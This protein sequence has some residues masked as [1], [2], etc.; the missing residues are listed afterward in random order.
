MSATIR[1]CAR[2][3]GQ[4][5]RT[6][7]A[8]GGSIRR[9][10][11][12]VALRQLVDRDPAA[13]APRMILSSMSVMFMT[14]VTGQPRQ[15]RWRTSRSAN[16]KRPEVADV[17][18]A[19][20]R[21]AARVDP[22]RS[23]AERH[24]RPG[25]AG[26]RVVEADGHRAASTMATAQRRDRPPGAL[27]AVE[28]AGRRLDVDG[29]PREAEQAGDRV[30]HRVE[31]VAQARPR[32]DDGHVDPPGRQPGGREPRRRPRRASRAL[33]MPERRRGAGR[34]QTAEV[35]ERR[36]PRAAHRRRRGGRRR[37]RSGRAAAAR[38][39]I[40]T[41]PSTQRRRPVRTDGCRG[42]CPMRACPVRDR[43]AAAAREIGGHGDLEV[44]R[45]ARD[46]MDRDAPPP[47][48]RPRPSRSPVRRRVPRDSAARSSAAADALG[49][50][51]GAERRSGR[52]SRRRR[53]PSIRLSVSATG[54]TGIAAP[55]RR[56]RARPRDERRR[57]RAAAR[58]RGRGPRDR[59]RRRG[60]RARR[61]RRDR[62][63]AS[64]AAGDDGDDA[65]G[66]HA[67]RHL[68]RR[69]PPRSRRR[70]ARRPGVARPRR[71]S[72]RA[73]AGRRA[74]G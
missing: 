21:R 64:R 34:E 33:S 17:G 36:P 42:R 46:D 32:G 7:H 47:A 11:G 19:V 59:P 51:G 71:G 70:S 74:R 55:C 69:G 22:D 49:R 8:E 73:A 20:D 38:P 43:A 37:R 57:R 28:V 10:R 53:S 14:H 65:E 13:A 5:V 67:R 66:S 54:T 45:V 29:R 24:E 40:S 9:N 62:L 18:R 26:Q 72:R 25:L 41:P 1:R 6:G 4:D 31:S 68:V 60:A 61:T 39:A 12:E 30:A 2:S 58:H 3:P 35:A 15:R 50:L 23:G 16:R 27:G 44:G 56:R 48:A 52:R 63:L